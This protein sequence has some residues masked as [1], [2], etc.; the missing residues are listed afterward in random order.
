M[1]FEA[2]ILHVLHTHIVA[3]DFIHRQ[4]NA[5]FMFDKKS[6]PEDDLYCR[7]KEDW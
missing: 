5:L 1:V 6:Q 2:G 7:H 3:Q 4:W